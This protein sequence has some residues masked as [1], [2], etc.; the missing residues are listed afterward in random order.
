MILYR[1]LHISRTRTENTSSLPK[2]AKCSGY[3]SS[4]PTPNCWGRIDIGRSLPMFDRYIITRF[5]D[6]IDDRRDITSIW[7]INR[8]YRLCLYLCSLVQVDPIRLISGS[9]RLFLLPR[10]RRSTST[11]S[12]L[13]ISS[14]EKIAP[15]SAKLIMEFYEFQGVVIYH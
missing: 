6:T 11:P 9:L 1:G 10:K 15:I 13:C 14:P 12:P 5:H 3:G 8:Q 4:V 2:S 7:S